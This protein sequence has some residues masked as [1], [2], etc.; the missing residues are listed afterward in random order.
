MCTGKSIGDTDVSA[1]KADPIEFTH[2][3]LWTRINPITLQELFIG[4]AVSL[5]ASNFDSSKPTKVFAHGWR[6]NG[7][8]NN[9]VFSLRD[10]IPYSFYD[11][12]NRCHSNRNF[13]LEFLAKE[14]CNF[15]AVDW[16]ELANNLNYY[17]S[18]ANTQPVGN[19]TGYFI[20]FLIAQGTNVNQFHVI[21]FSLGA[22]VA[23]KA[24]ALVNGLIPRVTGTLAV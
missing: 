16:E 13:L 11:S 6:M 24:G 9:A 4:D 7:Y 12:N 14:D 8:D 17:S 3:N 18:A 21:G 15:I 2:F 20:N 5:A 22:H 19:L 1:S 10:G 23:G